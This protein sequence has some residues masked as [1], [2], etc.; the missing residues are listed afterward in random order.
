MEKDLI[1]FADRIRFK[2]IL[3]NLLSNAVKFTTNAGRIDID[4][5]EDG[6]L[7][8]IATADRVSASEPRTRRLSS[9]SFARSK[10]RPGPSRK[11]PA[12]V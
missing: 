6:N 8:C 1:V 3:Y 12:W 7:V 2:Q 5:R 4:C 9:R 10:G 11:A